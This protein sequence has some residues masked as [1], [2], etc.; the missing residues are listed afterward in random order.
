MKYSTPEMELVMFQAIDDITAESN[1]N[2]DEV[3]EI[4]E[5]EL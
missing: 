1:P 3:G 5:P 4:V 2:P